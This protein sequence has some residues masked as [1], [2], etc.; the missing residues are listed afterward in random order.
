MNVLSASPGLAMMMMRVHCEKQKYAT[1]T[2]KFEAFHFIKTWRSYCFDDQRSPEGG[3]CQGRE[4]NSS[5]V[6]HTSIRHRE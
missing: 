5:E 2:I 4:F 6:W 3:S 1:Y